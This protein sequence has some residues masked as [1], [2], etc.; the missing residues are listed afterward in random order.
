MYLML[1]ITMS[2][3]EQL[4]W[5]S[6]PLS[7]HFLL[8]YIHTIVQAVP[9]MWTPYSEANEKPPKT[10]PTSSVKSSLTIKVIVNIC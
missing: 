5:S 10:N 3:Q 9:A 4:T 1:T 2:N 8:R 6:D 7:A